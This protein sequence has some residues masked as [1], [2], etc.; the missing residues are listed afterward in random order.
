MSQSAYAGTSGRVAVVGVAADLTTDIITFGSATRVAQ[1]FITKFNIKE[2]GGVPRAL[3]LESTANGQ[4]S[5]AGTNIRGGT[6]S[7][8]VSVEGLFSGI[9]SP[10]FIG[11]PS[12]LA[13]LITKK[14]STGFHHGWPGVQGTIENFSSSNGNAEGDEIQKC[15]FDIVVSGHLPAY[16][17]TIA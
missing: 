4:G 11:K 14:V 15:S 6:L 3:T 8:M 16:S 17:S 7:Y 9:E 2:S 10:A 5:L 13:N 12:V 1:V